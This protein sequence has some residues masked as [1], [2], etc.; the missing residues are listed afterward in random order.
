MFEYKSN[1]TTKSP[2]I[3][4]ENEFI[5]KVGEIEQQ[6]YLK[7]LTNLD[8]ATHYVTCLLST[9]QAIARVT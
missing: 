7:R 4:N 6:P 9:K 1:N 5:S 3:Q 8:F 2:K